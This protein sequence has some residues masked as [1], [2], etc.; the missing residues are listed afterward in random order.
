VDGSFEFTGANNV[1]TLSMPAL[2]DVGG[3]MNINSNSRLETLGVP[4][5]S[6]L[7]SSLTIR[8]NPDLTGVDFSALTC[9]SDFTIEGNDLDDDDHYD[10]LIHLSS[11]C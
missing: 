5:L 2:T 1:S 10:L 4:L 11:G 8:D 3:S 9:V 7:G 6:S